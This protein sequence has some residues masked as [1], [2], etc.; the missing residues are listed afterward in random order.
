[1]RIFALALSV[2]SLLTADTITVTVKGPKNQVSSAVT[3]NAAP[4][5]TGINCVPGTVFEGDRVS[6]TVIVDLSAPVGGIRLSVL[7]V[8]GVTSVV[9]PAGQTALTFSFTAVI[10]PLPPPAATDFRPLLMPMHKGPAIG[11][12]TDLFLSMFYYQVSKP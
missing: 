3:V 9:I 6:C 1:M 5:I 4:T 7:G 8:P 12:D 2:A 11:L 10:P